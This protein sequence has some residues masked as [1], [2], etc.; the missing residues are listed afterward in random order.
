MATPP[1]IRLRAAP[2]RAVF[3]ALM[4]V[5]PLLVPSPPAGAVEDP[6]DP[7]DT[8]TAQAPQPFTCT[9]DAFIVQRASSGKFQL[10]HADQ[11]QSPLVFDPLGP[12]HPV[13][14][15]N[16]TGFNRP[17]QLIEGWVKGQGVVIL[18]ANGE[19]TT[20]GIPTGMSG[21][22][23]YYAGDI[24]LDGNTY[25]LG[26]GNRIATIDLSTMTLVRDI[27]MNPARAIADY[28]VHPRTGVVYSVDSNGRVITIDPITGTT[29]ATSPLPGW[30]NTRG[31]V[32][33]TWF[34]AS[35][36][37]LAYQNQGY[38][39]E[40]DLT[41]LRV[42]SL[43]QGP[44]S[45][46]NDGTACVNDAI[47]AALDINPE[48][49]S[50]AALPA[51]I[52][53]DFVIENFS[54]S[55][56]LTSLQAWGDLGH[57]FGQPGVDWTL[58]EMGRRVG[59]ATAVANPNFDGVTDIELFAPGSALGPGETVLMRAVIVLNTPGVYRAQF[60]AVGTNPKGIIFGDT[61]TA[62]L[63]PD[64]TDNDHSPDELEVTVIDLEGAIRGTVFE[65][66]NGNGVQDAGE[67]VKGGVTVVVTLP[68][69]NRRTTTSNALGQFVVGALLQ[70]DFR[71]Q[72]DPPTSWTT[73][74]PEQRVT[75]A[76]G[77]DV[78]VGLI[79]VRRPDVDLAIDVELIDTPTHL[80]DVDWHITVSNIGSLADNGPVTLT[81][82]LEKGLDTPI[83]NGNGWSCVPNGIQMDCS[84]PLVVNP[85][86]SVATVA[87][88]TRV[89]ANETEVVRLSGSVSGSGFDPVTTNNTDEDQDVVVEGM[90]ATGLETPGKLALGL[91]LIMLG[92]ALLGWSKR[93]AAQLG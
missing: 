61:S 36:N 62:G 80:S 53:V 9:G 7:I 75:L 10:Y 77:Q 26:L 32:G 3:V 65:D 44:A 55:D 8:P 57:I 2:A 13:G 18:D 93:L 64:G 39:N 14:F 79:G 82:T 69:G 59:P 70:G 85:G 81:I 84:I 17:L 58:A 50:S 47:G 25:Y 60:G 87:L 27:P 34:T 21:N 74:T 89:I 90:A 15:L 76:L 40:I 49:S 4:V 31:P 72:A 35:G 92:T 5:I 41:N 73:T 56:P 22:E 19:M 24:S 23:H 63:D 33:A 83:A 45:G 38:L 42:I 54:A 86:T 52:A 11:T 51:R 46:S 6:P 43:Q 48:S 71:V 67:A 29:T 78:D 68:D 88:R 66:T 1:R 20:L 16:S 91:G 30:N 37:L 28:A 12:E